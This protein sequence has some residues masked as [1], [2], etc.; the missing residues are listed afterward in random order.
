MVKADSGKNPFL[1]LTKQNIVRLQE[2]SKR[3]G[4]IPFPRVGRTNSKNLWSETRFNQDD[5]MEKP[6]E[7]S[8]SP[9]EG[10]VHM[11]KNV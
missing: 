10:K 11:I 7:W 5:R 2:N 4:L 8:L 3:Q 6:G 1:S 9:Y